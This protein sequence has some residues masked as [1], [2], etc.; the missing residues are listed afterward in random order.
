[1][2][3]SARLR[4]TLIEIKATGRTLRHARRLIPGSRWGASE[5]VRLNAERYRDRPAL[6]YLDQRLTWGELNQAVDR[7]A[8]FFADRGV[9]QGDR[10]ALIMDNRPDFL[11]IET[12]L[13][14][15]GATAALINT[16]LTREPLIHAIEIG[17]PKL[18]VLGTE[19]AA[20]VREVAGSLSLPE[21]ALLAQ[22][23]EPGGP[24]SD[25]EEMN[26]GVARA[27]LRRHQPT[28]SGDGMCF[29]YTSGTTGLPKAA[30]ITHHR[31]LLA[32]HVFGLTVHQASPA[33]VIY[34]TLPLY[35]SSAQW[36]GWGAACTSGA[37]LALRRR[38]SASAFW[39]DVERFGAT[40]FT[41]IGELCRY[42]L[43]QPER[44]NERTHRLQVGVGNGLRPDIW[45][46]FT[47][48][49]NIPVMREFYGA[50]E[51]N[52]PMFNVEGR[53]GMVGRLRPGQILVRCDL[54]TGELVRDQRGR[55]REVSIGETGLLLGRINAVTRFDGYVD[56][57]ATSKKVVHGVLKV[58][59]VYF[60][61]GD[62]LVRH[63][64]GWAS[65]ADRVGDTFRFKG[66][67]VSTNEVG[68]VLNDAP[69]VLESNVY[70]VT[71]V[72]MEGRAG[73]ASLN[74]DDGFNIDAFAR[75]VVERLPAYQRPYFA[76]VQR[77]MRVT[78]TLK[79]QK[80]EYRREAYDPRLAGE[81]KLYFLDEGSYLPIDDA[82]YARLSSGELAP[83]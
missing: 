75:F 72:G 35:H 18:C 3:L 36:A 52:A 23:E 64:D 73:M 14:R 68:E 55:C 15:V 65:F 60:N 67:N 83:R 41:Y 25:F 43:N 80:V 30:I 2:G 24:S 32:A 11:L 46:R 82:L 63:A 5:L 37:A 6:L 45:E 38:F 34:V 62:L 71:V 26:A 1:M 51:G 4:S 58:G 27:A 7:Y 49:F 31:F 19:H 56:E 69:G 22:R 20:R 44:P 40:R 54:E 81:D 16:N 74:V 77:Q 47:G 10:V 53:P 33:D 12:A 29:I 39:D 50:T 21:A 17:R 78:Q 8:S 66:E 76:R 48:R 61:S 28:K 9:G 59:D 70:G 13:G 57:Q 42:L 79:H